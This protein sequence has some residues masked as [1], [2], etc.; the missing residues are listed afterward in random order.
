MEPSVVEQALSS[1]AVQS[2]LTDISIQDTVHDFWDGGRG[3][4]N[5]I[6]DGTL[7][8]FRNQINE[9]SIA[10]SG[11]NIPTVTLNEIRLKPEGGWIGKPSDYERSLIRKYE[12][13]FPTHLYAK[14]KEVITY[15][16]ILN[17]DGSLWKKYLNNRGYVN[18]VSII[19]D[20]N[21]YFDSFDQSQ[22]N[23]IANFILTFMFG[24]PA[25]SNVGN[26]TFGITYDAG[27]VAP[28]KVF[29]DIEQMYNYIYPQN[30]TDSAVTSFK[31][32]KIQYVF[33]KDS[34]VRSNRFTQGEG[35]SIK[36]ENR[37]YGPLNRYGF[38][39]VFQQG[40]TTI[41]I[42]FGPTQ[43]DGPSVNYLVTSY[44]YGPQNGVREKNTIADIS[45]IQPI[46]EQNNSVLFDLKRSGDFEQV[47]ASLND[48]NVIFATI[49][50]LCSFYA[51][52]LHKPCI[53]SNNASS[54]IVM[55]R[56]DVGPVDPAEE[57]KRQCLIFAQ[58][59][60]KRL[61]LL[62]TIKTT[63]ADEIQKT[64]AEFDRAKSAYYV[65][66]TK[67]LPGMKEFIDNPAGYSAESVDKQGY[68][69]DALTTAFL[70]AKANDVYTFL[71]SLVTAIREFQ[72]SL[73]SE[74]YTDFA[75]LMEIFASYP[76][77]FVVES[78]K[79]ADPT[80]VG[81]EIEIYTLSYPEE[82]RTGIDQ[83]IRY[84]K[85]ELE[86]V[87]PILDL[88]LTNQPFFIPLLAPNNTYNHKAS[89]PMF[90]FSAGH[91]K[92]IHTAFRA[93]MGIVFSG[94][95][96]RDRDKKITRFLTDYFAARETLL[97]TFYDKN[98]AEQLRERSDI[99]INFI[100]NEGTLPELG[101]RSIQ[102]VR[103]M[104]SGAPVASVSDEVM[105]KG[106]FVPPPLIGQ[107]IDLEHVFRDICGKAAAY[108]E[109][110][111]ST[112]VLNGNAVNN[113]DSAVTGEQMYRGLAN[114]YSKEISEDIAV[115]WETELQ[116]I[117][118]D[119][120]DNYGHPY[121]LSSTD[122][123]ISLLVS[124]STIQLP[125][126][127]DGISRYGINIH[128]YLNDTPLQKRDVPAVQDFY[129]K[130]LTTSIPNLPFF[131]EVRTLLALTV[132]DNMLGG[133]DKPNRYLQRI[134][135]L[136]QATYSA[137]MEWSV[138]LSQHIV[139]VVNLAHAYGDDKLARAL[140]K[141]AGGRR[142]LFTSP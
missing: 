107:T 35:L 53:W 103:N 30:I 28:R 126:G 91:F 16:Q 14:N 109:S 2:V 138:T 128:S 95:A 32:K 31:S 12:D 63:T 75:R 122:V 9:T 87:K 120:T 49:D 10:V 129:G 84:V 131:A 61:R 111:I 76:A 106:G 115:Y 71:I 104:N 121:Q 24:T 119:S 140:K 97:A 46:Y 139:N 66:A 40:L 19:P 1:G 74:Q 58:E 21:E 90:E 134:T 4:A 89:Q 43:S 113:G 60:V 81:N 72:P 92:S 36:F 52:M 11:K 132:F 50:H 93:M 82:G 51:R 96:G 67:V 94:R 48:N 118:E 44:L 25:D 73:S 114:M 29:A 55:Y 20:P 3:E 137:P 133:T 83:Q 42:P 26:K 102:M 62:A 27:P 18:I 85:N 69:T 141:L 101:N 39:W 47:H 34:L 41:R 123:L 100:I 142:P 17:D 5:P 80:N 8:T 33:P 56:F 70:R 57:F 13:T 98:V 37:G 22:K 130:L 127:P 78:R 59:Q 6:D 45:P 88:Q 64:I 15:N 136:P 108:V 23:K 124:A 125:P 112:F 110:V 105:Q 65:T 38:D 116:R 117:R 54:E 86:Q 79:I 68:L 7:T 77:K 99:P 135:P